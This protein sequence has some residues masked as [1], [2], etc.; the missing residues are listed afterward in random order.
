MSRQAPTTT[1]A[2]VRSDTR[3][4]SGLRVG[5][6]VGW[7]GSTPSVRAANTAPE[8]SAPPAGSQAWRRGRPIAEAALHRS[9]QR[10][11]RGDALD[12][13]RRGDVLAGAGGADVAA[14]AGV[15][16]LAQDLARP[17]CAKTGLTICIRNTHGHETARRGG[18]WRCAEANQQ[19]AAH[20]EIADGLRVRADRRRTL[21]SAGRG[22]A[23]PAHAQGRRRT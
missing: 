9:G 20:V 18:N 5:W 8:S 1:S 6:T 12:H 2:S 13:D 17:G 21:G 3:S 16:T 10:A 11:A 14:G 15:E 22:L 23:E 7:E 4:Q 19:P